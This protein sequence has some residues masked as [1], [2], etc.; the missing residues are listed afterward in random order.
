MKD[1]L[2]EN[3]KVNINHDVEVCDSVKSIGVKIEAARSG[4]INGNLIFY[5]PKAMTEGMA[6]FIRPFNK[7][8][9]SK[10]NG[11]AVG[12]IKEAEHVI[13]MFP[14]AS[15]EF[16]AIAKRVREHSEARNGPELVKAVK[17]LINTNEYN[18]PYYRGLGI[19][20]IY[21]DI[22]DPVTINKIRSKE[23][24][25]GTVSIGGKSKEVYCSVCASRYTREHDKVHK[26]GQYYNG[27][28]CFHITNDLYLDHCG[29]VPNPADRL[30][31]VQVVKD[32]EDSRLNID[33][34]HYNVQDS[35]EKPMTLDELKQKAKDPDAVKELIDQYFTDKDVAETAFKEY[36]AHLKNSRDNHH[37]LSEG[38]VLNL[39]TPVGVYVA[40]KLLEEFSDEDQDKSY[41]REVL[42]KAKTTLNIENIDQALQEFLDKKTTETPEEAPEQKVEDSEQGLFER[43]VSYFDTKLEE[44]AAKTYKVQDEEQRSVLHQELKH[45]RESSEADGEIIAN[46]KTDLAQSLIEQI[47]SLRGSATEDYVAKLKSRSLDQLKLTLEDLKESSK[48]ESEVKDVDPNLQKTSQTDAIVKVEDSQDEPPAEVPEETSEVPVEDSLSPTDWYAKR[49]KEVGLAK[50]LKEYKIKYK[51][52]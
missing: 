49:I 23:N 16:L 40:E 39:R 6:S 4:R 15:L 22:Y 3:N 8:L 11:E 37:L 51:T 43:L 7:H 21:G 14:N 42:D 2:E 20:T 29:F 34:T 35:T 28:L 19:A 38:K 41:L 1:R 9:Q 52:K 46:L 13:E 12:V 36:V 30:T 45:L 47:L 18:S 31:G 50:A 32:E 5:T 44:L 24:G 10:H 33:I 17:E 27:E 25:I 48:A 26:K